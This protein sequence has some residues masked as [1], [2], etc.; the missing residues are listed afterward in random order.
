MMIFSNRWMVC[1]F[2][3]AMMFPVSI[4]FPLSYS[5]GNEFNFFLLWV[6]GWGGRGG[7]GGEGVEELACTSCL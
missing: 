2:A 5:S 1:A 4:G 7:G 6:G 3:V